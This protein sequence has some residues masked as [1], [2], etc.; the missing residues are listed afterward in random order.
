VA[1]L[2]ALLTCASRMDLELRNL[3][4]D[5]EDSLLLLALLEG[6]KDA[7]RKPG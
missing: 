4:L 7:Q 1:T 5:D 6:S 2:P 3:P